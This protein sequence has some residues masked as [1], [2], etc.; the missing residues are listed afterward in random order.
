MKKFLK[1]FLVVVLFLILIL[2][3]IIIIWQSFKKVPTEGDWQEQLKILS[4]AE[5]SGNTVT[6]KNVRNFRYSPTESDMHPAY[7]DKTYDITKIKK[8]WFVVEPFNEHQ[9]LAHT[10]MSFEFENEDF[11]AISIEARK[12]KTQT[13]NPWYGM[14]HTYPL[15]YIAADER[16]VVM[17]RANVR[18][19]KVYIYPVK[20]ENPDNSQKLF[21]DMLTRMNELATTKPVWYNT[22]FANCTSSIVLH[23]NKIIPHRIPK[24]SW[25]YILTATIDDLAMKYGLLDTDL[26]LEEARK[27]YNINEASESLGDVIN[28]S[29]G[30]RDF[31][32][33]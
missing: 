10:F 30:I 17:L 19:D 24:L 28:Y 9:S 26:D 7:Y 32:N 5:F 15:V 2:I 33:K 21:V 18:K 22:I 1:K 14:L 3:L 29:T 31:E 4:T 16:D 25:E 8:V 11:L 23:V 6:V 13:W 20:L 27:K 12:T